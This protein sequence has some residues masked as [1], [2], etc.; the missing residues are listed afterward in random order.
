MCVNYKFG[1]GGGQGVLTPSQTVLKPFSIG[2]IKIVFPN[3]IFTYHGKLV[4]N[5]GSSGMWNTRIF[6]LMQYC[7]SVYNNS[8]HA[9]IGQER[10]LETIV[11]C[12]VLPCSK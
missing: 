7:P 6:G 8:V 2:S 10:K 4:T 11:S 12:E 3:H 5:N 9:L 1:G